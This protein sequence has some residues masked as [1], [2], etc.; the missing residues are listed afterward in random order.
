MTDA[1]MR[2]VYRAGKTHPHTIEIAVPR[3]EIEVRRDAMKRWA[4]QHTGGHYSADT[5]Q[6]AAG[7]IWIY[8]FKGEAAA[9]LFVRHFGD[10]PAG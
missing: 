4:D 5:S 8:E 2:R 10:E 9:E 3:D 6:S 1:T 7:S